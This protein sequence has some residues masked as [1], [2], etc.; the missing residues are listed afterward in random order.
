[1][2][3]IGFTP[4]LAPTTARPGGPAVDSRTNQHK[5]YAK[6]INGHRGIEKVC[7]CIKQWGGM[8]QFKVRGAD[9]G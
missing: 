4:H 2:R 5:G 6:S 9:K 1:M 8:R 3:G 7:G